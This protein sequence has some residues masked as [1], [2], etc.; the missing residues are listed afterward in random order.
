LT[1]AHFNKREQKGRRIRAVV[2]VLMVLF[3]W[4][5]V[6]ATPV[7][8][9]ETKPSSYVKRAEADI[10]V[11]TDGTVD[12]VETFSYHF[13]K[14]IASIRFDLIFP[15]EG[16]PHLS[17][18]EFAQQTGEGEDIYIQ[19][20][21]RSETKAQ[22]FSYTTH[23][24]RDR[25][26]VDLKMTKISEDCVFRLSYQWNRGVVH[27]EGRAL[28][29]GPLLSVRPET[30]V[31]TMRWT[32]TL[33]KTCRVENTSIIPVAIHTM[34]ENKLD[35]HVISFV[36]NRSFKKIDGISFLISTS[37]ACFPLILPASDP[38]TLSSILT[39]AGKMATR[40]SRLGLMR[41]RITR[42]VLPL[43]AAGLIIYA[44]L[45]LMQL[46]W[47]KEIKP[48]YALW[49]AL[50]RPAMVAKV[51]RVNPDQSRVLIATL[52]Q[53]INR[54]EIEWLDDV[55]IWRNPERNDFSDFSAWEIL[56]LQWLFTYEGAY[57]HVLAPERLRQMTY[58]DD[59]KELALRF[60]KQID[61]HY[62]DSGLVKPR[63]TTTFR[64]IFMVFSFVFALMAVVLFSISRSST[65][66]FLLIP[67]VIFAFG[68]LSFRF[69][70]E[71]GVNRYLETMR[72]SSK[73]SDPKEIIDSCASQLSEIETLISILPAAVV[74]GKT[75]Q[76]MQGI[77]ELPRRSFMRAAY[78]ILHVYRRIPMP[79]KEED[80]TADNLEEITR[81]HYELEE[82]ERVMA[83]WKEYFDN[84]FI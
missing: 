62:N 17:S 18:I 70:T 5:L 54:K 12:I 28:I 11:N 58:G 84:C 46:L 7:F 51:A 26:T 16:E 36:D 31:D 10:T 32:I 75:K 25:V 9:D 23:R 81:L 40:L 34:T 35:E 57:D 55:F 29:A 4:F 73:L 52:L 82:I 47:V 48:G 72:F 24:K 8:A 63:W 78:A 66:F 44:F 60:Q 43:V 39:R 64:I 6:P 15:F 14:P 20:P 2:L 42:I 74:L 71:S 27:K 68:S 76:Y 22:P 59:F 61:Q 19:I 45:Y 65:A 37:T 1:K 83:A 13:Q 77:R 50:A 3:S 67:A 79:P 80:R 53:L 56:L 21:E 38:S 41:D 69:L 33:P 49:P 30:Q